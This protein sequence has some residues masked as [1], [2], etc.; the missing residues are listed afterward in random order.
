MTYSTSNTFFTISNIKISVNRS[1]FILVFLRLFAMLTMV[2][3]EN[4]KDQA[5]IF[6]DTYFKSFQMRYCFE[7]TNHNIL[8]NFL[9]QK[10]LD[11]H[12]S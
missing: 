7:Q 6:Q 10:N 8:L 12:L 11:K 9:F 4:D 2:R 3:K 5:H 1:N